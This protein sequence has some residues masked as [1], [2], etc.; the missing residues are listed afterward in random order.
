M[1]FHQ[2]VLKPKRERSL[3]LRH[4]WVFSGAIAVSAKGAEE[5]DIVEILSAQQEILG[6][7]FFSQRSQIVCRMFHWGSTEKDFESHE[8]WEDKVRHAM[9][10]RRTLVI[11]DSTNAYR[12]IHAEGDFLPGV[13]LDVYAD[14]AVMQLLIKGTERRKHLLIKALESCGFSNIYV[15]AKSSS[16]VLEGIE[17]TSGWINGTHESPVEIIENGLKY[18]VDFIEGQKTGFFLDQRD[19]R[20]LLRT[21]SK[22]KKVL[23]C[24]SYTGGFSINALAGGASEVQSVDISASAI[25]GCMENV[26]LNENLAP[27]HTSLVQD[28]FDYL[29]EMPGDFYDIMVLDPPAFAKHSRAVDNAA[30]GYK[31]I[32]MRAIQKIKPGGIIFTFSCS[33][34]ISKELFQKII[35]GA[36]ADARRNVRILH[37]MHQAADHP[38]NIFHPEGEYLKGLV[39]WVE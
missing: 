39:L 35:F 34:N 27:R 38:I 17:T 8:Y 9:Q 12:L 30:R 2:L 15:K 22:G 24:F 26:L 16:E 32:N 1:K 18:K 36:A 13:I 33:Q 3:I 5:G 29:K 7:G 28:C 37:Q 23:N 21:M 31:Q 20:E 4:P 11:N 19:N 25:A 10:I 14:V 6:Y